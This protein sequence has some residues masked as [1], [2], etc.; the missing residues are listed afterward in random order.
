MKSR[1]LC[2]IGVSLGNN[3]ADTV[4]LEYERLYDATPS[5]AELTLPH[6]LR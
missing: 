5:L 6:P 4:L 2:L 3:Q 1:W